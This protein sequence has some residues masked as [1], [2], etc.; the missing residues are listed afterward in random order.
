MAAEPRSRVKLRRLRGLCLLF[1][2]CGRT[3]CHDRIPSYSQQNRHTSN[4]RCDDEIPERSESVFRRHRSLQSMRAN[5]KSASSAVGAE[6]IHHRIGRG[7][8][9][10]S[11]EGT[12]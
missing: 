6:G 7:L 4:N 3:D 8:F 9:T 12:R 5:C 2:S 11:G 10:S 1:R